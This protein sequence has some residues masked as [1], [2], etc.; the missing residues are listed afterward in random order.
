MSLNLPFEENPGGQTFAVDVTGRLAS[1]VVILAAVLPVPDVGPMPCLIYRFAKPDGSGFHPDVMLALT[2][3]Q[4][5]D[6]PKLTSDA[7]DSARRAAE[8][9]RS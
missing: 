6:L 9:A 2:D 1:G 4:A 8:A 3:D 5:A 7:V